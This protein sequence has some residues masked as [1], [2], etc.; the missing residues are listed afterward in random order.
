[1]ACLNVSLNKVLYE[2]DFAANITTY[3]YKSYVCSL[4]LISPLSLALISSCAVPQGVVGC[5]QSQYLVIKRLR[6]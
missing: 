6:L 1:M 4:P 2:F 3:Y 5:S